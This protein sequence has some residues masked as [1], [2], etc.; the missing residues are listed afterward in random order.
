M[1]SCKKNAIKLINSFTNKLSIMDKINIKMHLMMC[2]SC[3]I[4]SKQMDVIDSTSRSL[5]SKRQALSELNIILPLEAKKRIK[6]KL[7]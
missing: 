3:R 6:S 2:K 7:R 5:Y 1:L 4:F